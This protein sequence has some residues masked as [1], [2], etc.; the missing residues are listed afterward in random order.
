M[1]DDTGTQT[2][3][4]PM[5]FV[6]RNGVALVTGGTGGIGSAVCR[7]LAQRGADVAFVFRSDRDGA[8][9]L[10]D[11]IEALERMAVTAQVDLTDA[12]A[13]SSVV[14]GLDEVGGI[15]TLVHAAGPRVSQVFLST[16]D[17]ATFND[18]LNAEVAGF[19]NV[20]QPALPSLR[21]HSGTIVA[22]TS[23]A[24]NRYPV[25]DGLSAGPKAAIESLVRGL[26]AEEG[27]FGVRANAVGPGMLTDGMAEQ[28]MAAGEYSPRDLEIATQSIAMRRFGDS[29]DVAEAVCFLASERAGYIS[30]QVL[31]VDGGYTV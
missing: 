1:S 29:T 9:A 14:R 8:D 16:V 17:P 3:P 18:H 27:R 15:H 23:A 28:L 19:F 26:A 25:R 7:M 20:V 13:V 31:N 2:A 5:D 21:A 6:D 4:Q 12:D 24:T 22:V 10:I 11:E 30:G